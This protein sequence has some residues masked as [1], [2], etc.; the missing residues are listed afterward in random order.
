MAV[1]CAVGEKVQIQE[2]SKDVVLH[3][4]WVEQSLGCV[5]PFTGCHY[6]LISA[7]TLTSWS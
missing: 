5:N 6:E 7:R 4:A 2:C 1:P 3:R